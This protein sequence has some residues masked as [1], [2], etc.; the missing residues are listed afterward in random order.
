MMSQGGLPRRY[1][2]GLGCRVSVVAQEESQ[3]TSA[4]LDSE[5]MQVLAGSNP[6]LCMQGRDR[7]QLYS[8]S[9]GT[10]LSGR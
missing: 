3:L 10:E 4:G 8:L 1:S 5:D 6:G 2:A 9:L 7:I